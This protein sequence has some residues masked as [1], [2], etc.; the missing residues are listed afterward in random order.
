M[1]VTHSN[2]TYNTDQIKTDYYDINKK[3]KFS[4]S[5]TNVLI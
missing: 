1:I 3:Y 5:T 4:A 2:I